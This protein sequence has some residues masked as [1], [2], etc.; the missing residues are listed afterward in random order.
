MIIATIILAVIASACTIILA[1]IFVLKWHIAR[2]NARRTELERPVSWLSGK[3]FSS[4]DAKIPAISAPFPQHTTS[5]F[6][7]PFRPDRPA[8]PWGAYISS[9][10]TDKRRPSTSLVKAFSMRGS[11]HGTYSQQTPPSDRAFILSA[12]R[13]PMAPKKVFVRNRSWRASFMD[14]DPSSRSPRKDGDS[15]RPLSKRAPFRKAHSFPLS[16]L[17]TTP[18]ES[19]LPL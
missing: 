15:Y 19:M 7:L 17:S 2:R 4:P 5:L 12:V 10:R 11:R 16:P 1:S 6:P 13:P 14:G 8:R 9:E 3:S 18:E